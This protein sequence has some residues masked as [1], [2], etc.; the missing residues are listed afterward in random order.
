MR[1]FPGILRS[2]ETVKRG[3]GLCTDY[4]GPIFYGV[5]VMADAEIVRSH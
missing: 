3:I 4:N 2:I 1:K 5:F